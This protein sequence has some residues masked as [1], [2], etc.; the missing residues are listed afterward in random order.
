MPSQP[1]S[2]NTRHKWARNEWPDRER[3]CTKCGIRSRRY[4]NGRDSYW[5]F[6][7][8]GADAEVIV[9]KVPPCK[10]QEVP[11][12]K[13][14]FALDMDDGVIAVA[15]TRSEVMRL[16]D[17]PTS[18]EPGYRWERYRYGPGSEE[19]VFGFSDEDGSDS[20]FLEHGA[21]G[22]EQAGWG[23]PLE[24][25]R[26]AGSPVGVRM[27]DCERRKETAGSEAEVDQDGGATVAEPD[28]AAATE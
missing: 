8:P 28:Q 17:V 10:T 7:Y 24:K 26:Q 25:W 6:L 18:R 15:K 22:A 1:S 9:T 14:W 12:S 20:V 5:G 27:D 16:A 23:E 2:A 19:I 21:A 4:G 13:L 11:E 3:V